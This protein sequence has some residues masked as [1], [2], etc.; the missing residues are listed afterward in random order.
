MEPTV[1]ETDAQ[2][3]VSGRKFRYHL[4]K[5]TG[6][7]TKL[8]YD[9]TDQMTRPME[10][11]I[12]RAPTDNDMYIKQEWYR[13]R[14]DKTSVRAYDTVVR[15]TDDGVII[16]CHMSMAADTVQRILDM[17]TSWT[18]YTNGEISLSMSVT[19]HPEFP[20]L[21]RFGLRLFLDENM[22]QIKYYGMGPMESYV[23]K[24]QA[25]RISDFHTTVNENFE[26]Y[27]RP[28][29]NGSHYGCRYAAVTTYTG[30][31]LL[32][33]GD[34]ICFNAS[35]FTPEQLTETLHDYELKPMRETTVT[36]DYKQS[37]IGSN[38]CGPWLAG[39][40]Q[41]REP[42]FTF[43]LRILPALR[44]AIDPVAESLKRF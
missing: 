3:M 39:N 38:S 13:A 32:F 5:R 14:Y 20:M 23:D 15:K 24:R 29:E 25:A 12:W 22:N 8:E 4:D 17:D 2:V 27:V 11:N 18:V 26:H 28:Q 19:R 21:P 10:V 35:H 31:G 33:F 40:M 1:E 41:F 30:Q 43:R 7:F 9:G 34:D 37:G 16:H 36:V 42:S 6:L 44:A